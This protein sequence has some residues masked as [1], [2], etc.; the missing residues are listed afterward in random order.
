MAWS[1]G[2]LVIFLF[3]CFLRNYHVVFNR[4]W[5]RWL[6]YQQCMRRCSLY[7]QWDTTQPQRMMK[8]GN[9]GGTE[10]F[11]VKRNKSGQGQNTRCSHQSIIYRITCVG[12]GGQTFEPQSQ[13]WQGKREMHKGSNQRGPKKSQRDKGQRL[14]FLCGKEMK[15]LCISKALTQH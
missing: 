4:G 13:K 3:V 1:Y 14:E 6:F 5:T 15:S 8:L 2:A 12:N 10:G 9:L 7:T 11:H